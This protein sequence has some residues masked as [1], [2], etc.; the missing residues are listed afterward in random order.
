MIIQDWNGINR[1]RNGKKNSEN[2]FENEFEIPARHKEI[3]SGNK[4][5]CNLGHRTRAKDIDLA[6]LFMKVINAVTKTE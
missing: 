4:K 5:N 2:N 3:L 1:N 6:T